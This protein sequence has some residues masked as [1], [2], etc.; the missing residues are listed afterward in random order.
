MGTYSTNRKYCK[1]CKKFLADS[2]FHQSQLKLPSLIV[3][4]IDCASKRYEEYAVR[5]KREILERQRR[6][7]RKFREYKK[8]E[9]EITTMMNDKKF[10]NEINKEEITE[11]EPEPERDITLFIV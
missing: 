11:L 7:Q 1:D 9:K 5:K 10:V 4:C 8:N 2:F 3:M 6:K